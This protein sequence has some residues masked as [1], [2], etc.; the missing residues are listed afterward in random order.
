MSLGVDPPE[1]LAVDV[2]CGSFV[3]ARRG[4]KTALL[5]R[6]GRCASEVTATH[7]EISKQMPTEE[8]NA[9]EGVPVGMDALL[10][11][12]GGGGKV[13]ST[14]RPGQLALVRNNNPCE[15]LEIIVEA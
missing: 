6:L 15:Q 12:G 3:W 14:T 5:L 1:D 4:L 10:P 9:S 8:E 11:C 7:A 13:D 2:G